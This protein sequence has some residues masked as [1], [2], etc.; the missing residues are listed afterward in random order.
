[1]VMGSKVLKPVFLKNIQIEG[2][3]ISASFTAQARPAV[4]PAPL[5]P[6]ASPTRRSVFPA[7][8]GRS[9]APRARPRAPP[10]LVTPAPAAALA[11]APPATTPLSMQVRTQTQDGFFLVP[12]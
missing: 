11:P 12:A 1:M 4:S 6:Q 5:S 3:F 8:P 7:N 9:A 2:V 10:A